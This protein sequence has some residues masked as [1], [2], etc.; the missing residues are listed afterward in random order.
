MPLVTIP[1]CRRK[2]IQAG[3]KLMVMLRV[4]VRAGEIDVG[5]EYKVKYL[6]MG[7]DSERTNYRGMS[8]LCLS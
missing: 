4:I 8:N 3:Y 7:I 2:S 5:N 6:E 1:R